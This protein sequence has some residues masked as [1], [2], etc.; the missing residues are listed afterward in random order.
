MKNNI[1]KTSDLLNEF[2]KKYASQLQKEKIGAKK[3]M[4]LMRESSGNRALKSYKNG[5]GQKVVSLDSWLNRVS[6]DDVDK[7]ILENTVCPIRK[8]PK[9]Q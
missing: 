9:T 8:L 6:A 5:S 2:V 7:L 3:F 4:S 1:V